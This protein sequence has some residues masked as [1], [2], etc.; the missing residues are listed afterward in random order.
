MACYFGVSETL[1]RIRDQFTG[2][3]DDSGETNHVGI[4]GL[5]LKS[6][7]QI[8]TDKAA[9]PVHSWNGSMN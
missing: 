3:N 9:S 4:R 7:N 1:L 2:G 8:K 6:L 5:V